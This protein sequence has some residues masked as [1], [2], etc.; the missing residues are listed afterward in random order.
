MRDID[1]QGGN[2][3]MCSGIWHQLQAVK[4]NRRIRRGG[5]RAFLSDAGCQ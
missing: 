2:H 4:F 5:G 1:K 3:T